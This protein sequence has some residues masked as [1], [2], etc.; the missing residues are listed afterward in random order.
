YHP[1]SCLHSPAPHH[2]FPPPLPELFRSPPPSARARWSASTCSTAGARRAFGASST[3][4]SASPRWHWSASSSGGAGTTRSAAG[5]K[6]R[7]EEH[8]SE[9]QSHLN[10]VCRLLLQ[11]EQT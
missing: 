8:T 5:C 9:L 7:S 10:I 2:L 3:S 1:R 4:W 6:A 11:Q